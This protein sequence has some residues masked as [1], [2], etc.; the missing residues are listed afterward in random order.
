M[1]A[2]IQTSLVCVHI[3][4]GGFSL[5]GKTSDCDSEEQGSI[6]GFTHIEGGIVAA[7]KILDCQSKVTGSPPKVDKRNPSVTTALYNIQ[8]VELNC[9]FKH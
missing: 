9:G 2:F 6:P 7:V 8:K 5:S 4:Y 1:K 3:K